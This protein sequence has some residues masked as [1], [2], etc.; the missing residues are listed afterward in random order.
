M[1]WRCFQHSLLNVVICMTIGLGVGNAFADL[2]I[3][4]ADD[5]V[6]TWTPM[7]AP[8]LSANVTAEGEGKG[9]VGKA[10]M[11]V[12]NT[13]TN[14]RVATFSA[15]D[16]IAGNMY[17]YRNC[18]IEFDYKTLGVGSD[19]AWTLTN[20]FPRF[21]SVKINGPSGQYIV[22]DLNMWS[23]TAG[24]LAWDL[25]PNW[26]T[27]KLNIVGGLPSRAGSSFDGV[28]ATTTTLPTA[29]VAG[30]LSAANAAVFWSN[31]SS[32][33][34][35]ISTH[36]DPDP[37][38]AVLVDNLRLVPE[39]VVSGDVI[40]DNA[41]DVVATWTSVTPQAI[42][43]NVTAEGEGKDGIGKARMLVYNNT[44]TNNRSATFSTSNN[45]AG[46]KSGY[47][48][49]TIEFDYKT[50]G[51]G[52]DG[53]WTPTNG[54]PRFFNVN[55]HG[56]NG[57]W[58]TYNLCLWSS[59]VDSLGWDL[60]QEWHTVKLKIYGGLP[61]RTGSEFDGVAATTATLPTATG[62]GGLTSANAATFWANLISIEI[63]AYTHFDPDP[64]AAV[65]IDN[66]RLVPEPV[67]PK[68]RFPFG[69][70]DATVY[71]GSG[72]REIS[73]E[74]GN[75]VMPYDRGAPEEYVLYYL[76]E[77]ARYDLKVIVEVPRIHVANHDVA[78]IQ[79]F[80]R[81]YENH[82][83]HYGWYATDEPTLNDISVETCEIAYN[84]VKQESSKPVFMA[85]SAEEV[86]DR[87][88]VAYQ[89]AYDVMMPD[90]YPLYID[91]SQFSG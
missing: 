53:I 41:D 49:G 75:I 65:L 22:F 77:A 66:L 78:A 15:T 9:G 76:D 50:L 1:I 58:L 43:A 62:V 59:T 84:A 33:E 6:A 52:S 14:N 72:S 91:Q 40:V 86:D 79:N 71:H 35:S 18:T 29:T 48:N 37:S 45:I 5:V 20:G 74:G 34:V 32:I 7:T 11:L 56:P 85:F 16:N 55:L 21:F 4:N 54:F 23:F 39:P 46:D 69:W 60:D 12:Y 30:G 44:D 26:H 57:Q 28:E 80:V 36:F 87:A 82:P 89:N 3:D 90:I 70:Y 51:V 64:A 25:N 47:M 24:S 68:T 88:P 63:C 13:D 27:V 67:E 42:S 31:V 2:I 19:G 81:T 73:M 17:D 61:S 83:A 10:R 8:A 38:A